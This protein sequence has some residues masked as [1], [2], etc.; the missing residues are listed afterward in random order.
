MK[1]SIIVLLL[2]VLVLSG[3]SSNK[4]VMQTEPQSVDSSSLCGKTIGLLNENSTTLS[5]YINAS[6]K[7]MVA[8]LGLGDMMNQIK[9]EAES[10]VASTNQ[11]TSLINDSSS[12]DK[13][14][15][16]YNKFTEYKLLLSKKNDTIKKAKQAKDIDSL[17][18]ALDELLS[19]I[20]DYNACLMQFQKEMK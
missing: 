6:G 20:K 11:C 7:G 15:D 3:C 18:P 5:K 9:N 1:K 4:T 10:A 13:I 17:K 14:T 16:Y 8:L 2:L 19:A 12:L